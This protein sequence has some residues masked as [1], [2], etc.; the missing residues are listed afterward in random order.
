MCNDDECSP[1]DIN[2][3]DTRV[4]YADKNGWFSFQAASECMPCDPI[5][6][7]N[8]RWKIVNVDKIVRTKC[9]EE[10]ARINGT[11]CEM[12]WVYAFENCSV[13]ERDASQVWLKG[14]SAPSNCPRV[15]SGCVGN[16]FPLIT[17][18][19]S[20]CSHTCIPCS[21][22]S[23]IAYPSDL[24]VESLSIGVSL[25]WSPVN[26]TLYGDLIPGNLSIISYNVQVTEMN[27]NH[28]MN[29]KSFIPTIAISDLQATKAYVI[30]VQAESG[31]LLSQS[32]EHT[33]TTPECKSLDTA[34]LCM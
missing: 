11:S 3:Q 25:S 12:S 15:I 13:V 19:N 20:G 21:R 24:V 7:N 17:S 10:Y 34:L 32:V 30:K 1:T 18:S 23:E 33:V 29:Y 14:K 26:S 31:D 16:T 22:R 8:C 28:R 5:G 9:L 27:G 4:G 6:T 2:D